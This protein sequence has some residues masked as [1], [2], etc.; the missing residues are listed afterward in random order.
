MLEA[1]VLITVSLLY[2]GLLFAVAW[3]VDKR[4]DQGRSL[5]ASPTL[6][7]LSLPVELPIGRIPHLGCGR[8]LFVWTQ[9]PIHFYNTYG[10]RKPTVYSSLTYSFVQNAPSACCGDE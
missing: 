7:A 4:A 2:L 1:P 8:Y 10:H 3:W 6:Y 9:Q 5:I